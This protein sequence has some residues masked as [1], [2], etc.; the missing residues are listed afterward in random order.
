[1]LTKEMSL[2]NDQ[3]REAVQAR[4]PPTEAISV[5]L[6]RAPFSLMDILRRAQGDAF[7]AFGLDPSE[8]AYRVV[9]SGPYW[10]LR[11]YS[12]DERSA[13]LLVIAAPIKRPYI[14]D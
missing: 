2:R 11:D 6:G 10:R 5:D 8:C 1:M 9:A 14:W 7:G 3:G 12:S 13:A 4:S